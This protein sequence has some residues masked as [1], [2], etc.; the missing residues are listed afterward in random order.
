MQKF[1]LPVFGALLLAGILG[2]LVGRNAA[3]HITLSPM[4]TEVIDDARPKE[5]VV[6]FEGVRDG[7]VFGSIRGDARVWIGETQVMPDGEGLFAEE[8]GPLLVNE[9]SVLV[10]EGMKFVA[11]KRGK[12]YYSVLTN[13]GQK[14]VP[15]NRVYFPDASAAEAAGY[16]R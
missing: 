9:I 1:P 11:S 4:P 10:P 8:P 6:I 16:T 5:S 15:E 13:G 14:I 7:K 12:K 2:Y 3:L